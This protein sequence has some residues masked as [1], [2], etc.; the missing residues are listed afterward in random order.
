MIAVLLAGR[1]V[2]IAEPTPIAWHHHPHQR[3]QPG[4]SACHR[5][6]RQFRKSFRKDGRNGWQLGWLDSAVQNWKVPAEDRS[7]PRFGKSSAKDF[8]TILHH[9]F[10]V[11]ERDPA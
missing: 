3:S 4:I 7:E 5:E 8:L 10:R 1:T 11:D 2:Q 9:G 6:L